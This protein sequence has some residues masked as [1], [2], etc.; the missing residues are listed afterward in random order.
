MLASPQIIPLN[1][2]DPSQSEE[3]HL[4]SASRFYFSF[5]NPRIPSRDTMQSSFSSSLCCSLGTAW[6]CMV[7]S[8]G[9]LQ[10]TARPT[11]FGIRVGPRKSPDL[12]LFPQIHSPEGMCLNTVILLLYWLSHSWLACFK[13]QTHLQNSF[14]FHCLPNFS[15]FSLITFFQNKP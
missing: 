15:P 14:A 11:L 9:W 10:G 7:G 5:W 4:K 3:I 8:S 12:G 6:P 2:S 13:H 1:G